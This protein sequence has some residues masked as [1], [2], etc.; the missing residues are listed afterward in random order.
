MSRTDGSYGNG[1][2]DMTNSDDFLCVDGNFTVYTYYP[3]SDLTDGTIEVKGNFS[4]KHYGYKN[5][6]APS[7]NHKVILSGESL[8]TVS[9]DRT[10][11]NFNILEIQ[12]FSND[13][14]VFSTPVTINTLIDNGCNVSF[15]NGERSGWTLEADE[16]IEGDLFLSRGSLDLNGHKL[17]ITGNLVHSGGTVLVNGGELEVQSDYR[18]QSLNGTSYTNSTGILNM[19]NEADAVKVFGD[20]VMQSTVSHKDKLTAGTLEVDGD[21][22]QLSG[23][24]YYNFYTSGTHTIILNGTEKQTVSI[25]NN[26]KDYSRIN[27]L[28]IA[29]TSADGVDF[30]RNVYVIGDL[31]YTSSIITNVT[32]LYI[33]STAR[34]VDGEWSK[35]INFVENYSLNADLTVGGNVYLTGGT[36]K[37]N[38]HKLLVEGDFNMSSTN[39]NNGNSYINMSNPEDYISVN[40]NFLAYSYYASTLTDG[41]IEVKG[42]FTQRKYNYGYSNNFA[43]SGNHKV[44]LSGE[45][46]QTVSFDRTES[47][48]NILEIQNFSNDGVVFS[49]PVTINT[50]IDNGCNVS[51]ANGELSGWT[52]EADETIEGDLFLSR[53]ILDLNGYKLTIT[54]N[55]VHSGGTVLVNGGELEVQ[56]DYRIQSLSGSTYG[57]SAG[58][59][60]MTNEADTVKV[61]GS[62]AMQSTVSHK[63][64]LTAGTLEIGGDL[65][66]PEGANYYSFCPSGNHTITLNGTEK[67]TVSIYYSY[68]KSNSYINNLR[69]TNISAEGVDFAKVAYVI[70][71]LYDTG[72]AIANPTNLYVAST[73]NFADGTWS[74]DINFAENYSLS[75]DLKIGGNVYLAS[76]TL[77]LNGH[78]LY[79]DGN[80]YMERN[81]GNYSNGYLN[82][83]NANDYL[84][85]NG[86]FRAYSYYANTALTEGVLEI[87]GDFTQKYYNHTNNFAPSGNHK[88][89]LS[90]EGL[91]TVGFDRTESNFNILEIQNYSLDVVVFSTPVTINTLI[92]N[93]CNVSFAN[94]ER[95]GW[96]LEADETIEG[97]MLISRGIL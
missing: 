47:N 16:T 85:V 59:L 58:I 52:L 34:F 26:S 92:D 46:L 31:Y 48:F 35:E 15:V 54:G 83:T 55:L 96:M 22:T 86:D 84:F 29:N 37:P 71:E 19:T 76:G 43:P 66:Q 91:Q 65:L 77:K 9:F 32:N 2:L 95:S 8:Q 10:E 56:G 17:T 23:G 38:G 40:G 12:N 42:D 87:K 11:S 21:L 61:L 69:I 3:Y 67:Q 81:N 6:F 88:V 7:G 27:N 74:N 62:F 57:N 70:G 50:L 13:G 24:S 64:K 53:G 82:M 33:A 18:V 20:F 93:G 14:I 36:F 51:F 49:T 1:Y 89:M 79:V 44:I 28:K 72:A 4:Q 25:Y 60:N 97:D 75:D 30:A 73:T 68:N 5:N 94:G 39:G 80:F 78:K 63:D 41:I 90:G 45:G